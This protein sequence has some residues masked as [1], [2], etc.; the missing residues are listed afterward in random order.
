MPYTNTS[1]G[2]PMIRAFIQFHRQTHLDAKRCEFVSE[3]VVSHID[4]KLCPAERM[5]THAIHRQGATSARAHVSL[6]QAMPLRTRTDRNPAMIEK[7]RLVR[8]R[9]HKGSNTSRR[10]KVLPRFKKRTWVVIQN[11]RARMGF[12]GLGSQDRTCTRLCQRGQGRG[13][14]NVTL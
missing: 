14:E 13:N 11:N 4:A 8:P 12:A 3:V 5:V 1:T 2:P 9:C 10:G 7:S 6:V